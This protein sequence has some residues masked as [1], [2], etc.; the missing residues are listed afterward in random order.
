MK[1]KI[2]IIIPV[3]NVE[4]Y[5]Q[6]SLESI[7]NQTIGFENLE[8]IMVNDHSTDQS[9]KIIDQYASKYKNFKAIHLPTN[10]G[11]PGKPRN[12]GIEKSTGEYL[13]FLDPDDYFNDN[14]CELLYSKI[15]EENA[16]IVSGMYSLLKSDEIIE[17]NFENKGFMDKKEIILQTI[18]ENP[19]I[20]RLP[21]AIWTKI[22]KHDFIKKNNIRFPEEVP[23]EDFIFVIQAMLNAKKIVV[24][25]SSV[26][27]YYRIRDQK[28]KS[29]SFNYT[30][31]LIMGLLDAYITVLQLL[32][33]KGKEKY[34]PMTIKDH[35][36]YW[37]EKISLS[38]LS[39][40][41]KLK[42]LQKSEIIFEKC[43]K[44]NILPNLKHTHNIFNLIVHKKFG[45]AILS[46]EIEIKNFNVIKNLNNEL[47]TGKKSYKN[48]LEKQKQ[49][50]ETKLNKQKQQY[51]TKLN[52][53]KQQYETK[54]NKQKQ[55]IQEIKSSNSWKITKPLRKINYILKSSK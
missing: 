20:L 39:Y 18:D 5:L 15:V 53:Q 7:I 36:G 49:Q 12:V 33:E 37:I 24:L 31:K 42:A 22:L 6:E 21:P 4:D 9:G 8:I 23:G 54:L 13:M 3:F 44:D 27:Y 16:D 48:S 19:N 1:Y 47:K 29:L 46:M 2:S 30:K 11:S 43:N 25:N 14:T 10:S 26:V 51:E 52:K 45:A 41:D 35:L 38:D 17:I 40:D 28:D 50:Y 34:Y 32:T 55:Q